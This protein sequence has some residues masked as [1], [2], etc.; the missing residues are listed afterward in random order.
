MY[1]LI[2][3]SIISFI[4]FLRYRAPYNPITIFNGIW[5]LVFV[6][7]FSGLANY[8]N[9]LSNRGYVTFL[10]M[11]IGFNGAFL[12]L[13]LIFRTIQKKSK[14][15]RKNKKLSANG[16]KLIFKVWLVLIIFEAVYSRGVPILWVIIGSSKNYAQFGIP[17]LHGF[18]NS[19][20][21]VVL[22]FAFYVYLDINVKKSVKKS[23]IRIILTIISVYVILLARQALTTAFIQ[24][25]MVYLL[26]RKV[27]YAKVLWSI[28]ISII[29]FGIAGN[30]R[31]GADHFRSVARLTSEVPDYLLGL[32]WVLM[33]IVTPIGNMDSLVNYSIIYNYGK[34]SLTEVLPSVL[35][36]MMK[37]KIDSF[38]E[39]FLNPAFNTSTFLQVPYR[40]FGL[41]GVLVFS[42]LYGTMAYVFWQ[43]YRNSNKS[44]E[45]VLL[46]AVISQIIL[47]SFFVNML[48]MLPIIIQFI[49]IKIFFKIDIFVK[50]ET[51]EIENK[52]MQ[53]R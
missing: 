47:M 23:M 40:D 5:L 18:V 7:Y 48:L 50:A 53:E 11:I 35:V 16:I 12:Y 19:L 49:Y 31:S 37:I 10:L 24:M 52:L 34:L 9:G 39:Y 21:W 1:L 36:D 27:N 22:I 33:Y 42:A 41:L 6:L 25:M 46:Y 2:I 44:A 20:S 28:A 30:F 32:Y 13:A 45:S 14:F 43:G 3:L 8:A 51:Y 15:K 17:T 26:T 29:F 4:G 38:T